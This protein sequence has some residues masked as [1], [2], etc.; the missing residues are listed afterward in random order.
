MMSINDYLETVKQ[1]GLVARANLER[2]LD[3]CL[4]DHKAQ[5]N[6]LGRRLVLA[7][8]LTHWQNDL[9][10]RGLTQGFFL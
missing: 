4:L 3:G 6:E 1:S 9:L 7:G 8:W 2:E 5:A 10:Q